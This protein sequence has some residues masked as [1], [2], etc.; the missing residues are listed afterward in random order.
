MKFEK[1]NC[2]FPTEVLDGAGRPC[3]QYKVVAVGAGR[4]SCS[5]WLCYSGVKVHDGH[6]IVIARR[7]LLRYKLLK[8][9]N[10]SLKNAGVQVSVVI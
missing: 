10:P 3:E 4:S 2:L 5:E 1:K 9:L 7:A 6:A 8:V